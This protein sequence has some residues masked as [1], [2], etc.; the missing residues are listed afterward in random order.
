MN[1][2]KFR[3]KIIRGHSITTWTDFCPF[4]TTYL[5]LVD[6]RGHLDYHLPFV[7][8]DTL[9]MTQP[10]T[11]SNNMYL[12]LLIIMRG[13]YIRSIFGPDAKEQGSIFNTDFNSPG[14]CRFKSCFSSFIAL[15]PIYTFVLCRLN[16]K[17]PVLMKLF[18]IKIQTT[19]K[20]YA[21]SA[22]FTPLYCTHSVLLRAR[23][24]LLF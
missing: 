5:P 11:R 16:H 19:P 22:D 20:N 18:F 13:L 24:L 17:N 7:H 14:L 2:A 1:T 21:N 8:V 10:P 6:K 4:L 9:K 15:I 3:V 23:F 12:L